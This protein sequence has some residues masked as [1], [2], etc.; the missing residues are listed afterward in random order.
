M[1][2][3]SWSNRPRPWTEVRA[4]DTSGK[5][6]T[7]TAPSS[8]VMPST[9]PSPESS[10]INAEWARS[11]ASVRNCCTSGLPITL[12]RAL[13]TNDW[14]PAVSVGANRSRLLGS[15]V[16]TRDS[17]SMAVN[18]SLV[19]HAA[20]PAST[21]GSAKADDTMS[22]TL[23]ESNTVA[24]AHTPISASVRHTT[25]RTPQIVATTL[26]QPALSS[27]PAG[28][29]TTSSATSA[30]ILTA[31]RVPRCAAS[32]GVGESPARARPRPS[33][34]LCRRALRASG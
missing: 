32:H 13:S 33:R 26:R 5:R 25:A 24:R 8:T 14:A 29:S 7:V 23:S 11:T 2:T 22:P 16:V 15:T 31:S 9:N 1:G 19:T 4:R 10:C 6:L 28:S 30:V 27:A 20:S 17:T 18:S 12:V 21:S 3:S 34:I